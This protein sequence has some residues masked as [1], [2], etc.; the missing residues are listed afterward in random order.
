MGK[1]E[2]DKK[3]AKRERLFPVAFLA[4]L[5]TAILSAASMGYLYMVNTTPVELHRE[6]TLA[7][8]MQQARYTWKAYLKPN[9]VYLNA[10]EIEDTT[11]IYM[12]VVKLLEIRLRYTFTSNPLGN[13][14][15]RYRLE[16]TLRSPKED[17]WSIPI[18]LNAS[19]KG[20]ETFTG[21][22]RLDVKLTLDPNGYW[23]LIK[24]VERETGTYSSEYHIEVSP[25]IEVEADLGPRK[26][27]ETLNPK[28]TVKLRLRT[29]VGDV[30][31]L[32][33]M[34]YSKPGKITETK[35]IVQEDVVLQ[36]R[37]ALIASITSVSGLAGSLIGVAKTRPRRREE[38]ITR[39]LKQVE[40]I[41]VETKGEPHLRRGHTVVRVST[42]EDLS[43]LSELLMKPILASKAQDQAIL[44][45]LDGQVKY[46]Y[47]LESR[48]D[49]TT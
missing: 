30:I 44:Y 16:T 31:S 2:S 1:P 36:R 13:V 33:G 23:D 9:V 39:E 10:S 43:K 38:P 21:E 8:Y 4:L 24:T 7:T 12:R 18:Q 29:D 46:V 20:E 37:Y 25:H 42:L 11:P 47:K 41:L 6:E 48:E 34:E 35:I 45:V 19:Y 22:A 5:I 49:E 32:E 27:E 15:V 3:S 17:G 28:L 40:D 14:T 26:V